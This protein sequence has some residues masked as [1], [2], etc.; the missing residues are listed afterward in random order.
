MGR[1]LFLVAVL[2]LVG[3]GAK[4]SDAYT[5]ANLALLDAMPVYPGA[6]APKT[7]TS[8]AADVKFAGRD[9]KLP[10]SAS[11]H[12]VISWYETALQRRGW[13]LI[14][15]SFGTIRALR[16]GAALSVGVR[17]HR[18]EAIANSRGG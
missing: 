2:A 13:K 5:E 8:G 4:K 17:G 16:R 12:V 15:E 7:T 14:G 9:W 1:A 6:T 18:L 11:E 3:C 10:A